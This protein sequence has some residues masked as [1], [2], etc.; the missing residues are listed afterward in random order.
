LV[1]VIHSTYS[2]CKDQ[3]IQN[4]KAVG[5]PQGAPYYWEDTGVNNVITMEA[6]F[7]AV[8]MKENSSYSR[9]Q[10]WLY[11]RDLEAST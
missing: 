6:C 10:E 11:Q 2:E 4:E 5:Y 7:P 3:G 1:S 8:G 9:H